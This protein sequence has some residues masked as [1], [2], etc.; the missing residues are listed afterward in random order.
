MYNISLYKWKEKRKIE[1]NG[2]G[3]W[4]GARPLNHEPTVI[5]DFHTASLDE[6]SF[7]NQLHL[8]FNI[9]N[10]TCPGMSRNGQG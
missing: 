7:S 2:G 1:L 9:I 4:R 8:K 6:Y 3:W 5:D 10:V